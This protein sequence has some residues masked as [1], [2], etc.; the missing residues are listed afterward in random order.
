ME[1]LEGKE[2]L[3]ELHKLCRQLYDTLHKSIVPSAE[4]VLGDQFS[5][6]AKIVYG[7]KCDCGVQ[8]PHLATPSASG[9]SLICQ[10]TDQRR[11]SLKQE[12]IWFIPVE[13]VEV[14]T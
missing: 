14:N 1:E 8:V 9:K 4:D 12:R 6:V 7:V 3:A 5:Q 2:P 13:N 10:A 11:K